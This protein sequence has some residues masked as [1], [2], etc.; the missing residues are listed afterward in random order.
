MILNA[1]RNILNITIQNENE[2]E[3]VKYINRLKSFHFIFLTE[4]VTK[5]NNVKSTKILCSVLN[6]SCH[7][8]FFP[9]I[10]SLGVIKIKKVGIKTNVVTSIGN[11]CKQKCS[12]N[13]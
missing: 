7:K 13:N 12:M 3:Y 9:L 5:L 10:L 4:Y 2:I 6:E 11:I 1:K 8:L